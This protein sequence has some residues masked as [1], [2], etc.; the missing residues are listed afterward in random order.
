MF[1]SDVIYDGDRARLFLAQEDSQGLLKSGDKPESTL[2]TL[3]ALHHIENMV[4]SN[5]SEKMM[6]FLVP[7]T[8]ADGN[9]I[10]YGRI[11]AGRSGEDAEDWMYFLSDIGLATKRDKYSGPTQVSFEMKRALLAELVA[12][13]RLGCRS[14]KPP[15]P[16]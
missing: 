1:D 16:S 5:R 4:R 12:S 6:V 10:F 7:S 15:R 11:M 9:Q 2:S 8:D 14:A 13:L 3:A